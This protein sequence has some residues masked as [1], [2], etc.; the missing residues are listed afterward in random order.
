MSTC[1]DELITVL[2]AEEVKP[3]PYEWTQS[4]KEVILTLPLPEGCNK[5]G[6][7]VTFKPDHLKV[8][9]K[10]VTV[11]DAPLHKRAKVEDSTWFIEDGKLRIELAK[12]KSDEWWKVSHDFLLFHFVPAAC[13]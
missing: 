5:R 10:G 7:A 2:F 11:V 3:L 4:L 1:L 13:C 9:I 6:V 8:A 12:V